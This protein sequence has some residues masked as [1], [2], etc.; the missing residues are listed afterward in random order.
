MRYMRWVLE[1]RQDLGGLEGQVVLFWE[2]A[3]GMKHGKVAANPGLGTW[4]PKTQSLAG[5]AYLMQA[6]LP[7]LHSV[8]SFVNSGC[9]AL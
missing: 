4:S 8:S 3:R 9:W 2:E 5:W 6:T 1:A 7:F